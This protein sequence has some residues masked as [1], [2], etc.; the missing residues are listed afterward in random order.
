MTYFVQD[1]HDDRIRL[2]HLMMGEFGFDRLTA[3][4]YEALLRCGPLPRR[5]LLA[6]LSQSHTRLDSGLAVLRDHNLVSVDYERFQPRYYAINPA[7]AWQALRADILWKTLDTMSPAESVLRVDH[8]AVETL[9]RTC[10]D[11]AGVGGRLYRHH[12]AA[13]EHRQWDAD[14]PQQLAHLVCEIVSTA[15]HE[16]RAVSKSPRLPQVSTFW[17]VLTE[18]LS[19]GVRYRRVVDLDEVIAHGLQVVNRDLREWHIDLRVLEQDRIHHKYY[20]VDDRLVAVFHESA[21]PRHD[22]RGVGRISRK[23]WTVLKYAKRFPDYA[24]LAIPADLVVGELRRVSNVVLQQARDGLAP[25]EIAWLESLIEMG[26]FSLF[27]KEVGWSDARLSEVEA[28]ASALGLARRNVEGEL[29][30]AYPISAR[31]LRSACAEAQR[32]R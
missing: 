28:K 4:I 17:T 1:E 30:F 2:Q 27:H 29:V 23:H 22:I 13:L 16:V 11:L 31:Q 32:A 8:P 21:R 18:R 25:D 24:R 6:I 5:Q 9:L 14:T 12:I 10:A 7:V 20:I 26:K 15:R 19:A 3:E